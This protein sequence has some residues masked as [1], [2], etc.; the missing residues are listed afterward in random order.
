SGKVGVTG[1]TNLSAGEH[2]IT[3]DNVG[4]NFG[5]KVTITSAHEVTIV[6]ADDLTVGTI[7]TQGSG[8]NRNGGN[9]R[10]T[11]NG[12]ITVDDIDTSGLDGVDE[13][14]KGGNGGAVTIRS[15]SGNVSIKKIQSSGGNGFSEKLLYN[16]DKGDAG[17]IEISGEKITLGGDLFSQGGQGR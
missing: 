4:N 15:T 13:F 7:N 8:S 10:L 14:R 12:A 2:A 1:T 16:R 11:A 5:E 3:L 9:V 6:D 17:E